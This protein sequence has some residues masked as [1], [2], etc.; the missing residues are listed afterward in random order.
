L[1]HPL[2][3]MLINSLGVQQSKPTYSLYALSSVQFTNI[4][5]AD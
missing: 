2:L 1:H 5:S 4:S 3:A